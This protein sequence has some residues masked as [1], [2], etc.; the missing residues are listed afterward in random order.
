M[1]TLTDLCAAAPSKPKGN[2]HPRHAGL[3][4]LLVMSHA[5]ERGGFALVYSGIQDYTTIEHSR[6]TVFAGGVD[7]V[8]I[9]TESSGDPVAKGL[10]LYMTCVASGRRMSG[11]VQIEW[12]CTGTDTKDDGA[13]LYLTGVRGKGTVADGGGGAG[14]IKIVGGTGRFA[15]F[16][17]MCRARVPRGEAE[18]DHREVYL[19]QIVKLAGILVPARLLL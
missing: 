2:T 17:G 11:E 19:G 5:D 14:M 13:R 9:V 15:R 6:G 18:R 1:V 16:K 7:G 12:S 3:L 10:Q 4:L 8:A